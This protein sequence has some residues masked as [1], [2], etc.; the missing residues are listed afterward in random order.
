MYNLNFL[1]IWHVNSICLLFLTLC[2]VKMLKI[3]LNSCQLCPCAQKHV[4]LPRWCIKQ[5]KQEVASLFYLFGNQET[6]KTVQELHFEFTPNYGSNRNCSGEKCTTFPGS[7]NPKI[8]TQIK[9]TVF[10]V[11][12]KNMNFFNMVLHF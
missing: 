7:N 4:R 9:K 11:G 10:L 5:S 2:V 6:E 1:S 8:I 3:S 12:Q